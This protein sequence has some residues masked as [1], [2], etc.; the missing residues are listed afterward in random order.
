MFKKI[1]L[2]TFFVTCIAGAVSAQ[3]T[4]IY[5]DP[6]A[7]YNRGLELYD[8]EKYGSAINEFEAFI[9]QSTDEELKT[10]SQFYIAVSSLQLQHQAAEE[11]MKAFIKNNPGHIK[12]NLAY[13]HL[14]R[15]YYNKGKFTRVPAQLKKTNDEAL[16]IDESLEYHFMLGYSYFKRAKWANAEVELNTTTPATTIWAM[17]H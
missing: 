16:T 4:A 10:N 8:K 13:F 17:E 11:R 3:K 6:V 7:Y 14:G 2:A 1:I 15:Y 5:T 12:T 9:T